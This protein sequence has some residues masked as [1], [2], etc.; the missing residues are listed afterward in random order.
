MVDKKFE[1]RLAIW[2]QLRDSLATSNNPIQDVIDYWNDIPQGQR[3]ADPFDDKT[4]PDPWEMIEEN[5]YCE[6][7]KILAMAYTLKLSKLYDDWQP[8][9]KIGLD[10]TQSR[11]YYMLYLDD[12][13]IGFNEEKSVHISELPKNIHIEKIHVMRELY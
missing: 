9:I 11:M 7:T 8:I 1:D 12:Q 13:V 5:S 10:R 3:N 6:F 2:R 4:W